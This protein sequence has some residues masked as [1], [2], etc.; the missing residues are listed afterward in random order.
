MNRPSPPAGSSAVSRRATP[1]T[2]KATKTQRQRQS[3]SQQVSQ[4]QASRLD[5]LRRGKNQLG[6]LT[7]R[8][9]AGCRPLKGCSL[10]TGDTDG[11]QLLQREETTDPET[12]AE[13]GR[14]R[15]AHGR[16]MRFT[17]VSTNRRARPLPPSS[18]GVTTGG[19][20]GGGG[21]V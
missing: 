6:G 16:L 1:R 13:T 12:E 9:Q 8:A 10:G 19:G 20:G 4:H 7:R 11:R 3:P 15:D 18:A 21:G 5:S 14:Q 17:P 2:P